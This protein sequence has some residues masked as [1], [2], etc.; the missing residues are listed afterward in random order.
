[1]RLCEQA[2]Y[3]KKVSTAFA[4]MSSGSLPGRLQWRQDAAGL[5]ISQELHVTSYLDRR[6][7]V[8]SHACHAMP[9]G[10]SSHTFSNQA[11]GISRCVTCGA[12]SSSRALR[13]VQSID[14]YYHY[15]YYYC[16]YYYYYY[17]YCYYYYYFT[18][19]KIAAYCQG[20][21]PCQPCDPP[22]L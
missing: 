7:L 18:R 1:M 9:G 13:S 19:L 14:Y 15:H 2:R 21:V 4:S 22:V 11:S 16:Y 12:R 8:N 10:Q 20:Y 17:Y 3:M 6:P 5:G